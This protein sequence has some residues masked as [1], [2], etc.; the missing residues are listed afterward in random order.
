LKL[1]RQFS[2][3]FHTDNKSLPA[4]SLAR[5]ITVR[6][7]S[8]TILYTG[9]N[10]QVRETFFTPVDKPGAIIQLEVET[11]Q[12][13]EIEAVFRP[14]FELEWPAALGGTY[15][16]WDYSLHAVALP[17]ITNRSPACS[18]RQP[19]VLVCIAE[20]SRR[21]HHCRCEFSSRFNRVGFGNSHWR[22]R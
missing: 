9:D 5:T 3:V 20:S 14:Q 2:L 8:T 15:S 10:F 16:Y 13:L 1:F 11:E 12:A 21:R 18:A 17:Q 6:P 4:E 7:E 22:H 19:V